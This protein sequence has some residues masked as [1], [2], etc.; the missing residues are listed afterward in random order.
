MGCPDRV[1]QHE[2]S[3][4]EACLVEVGVC[5]LNAWVALAKEWGAGGRGGGG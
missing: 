1:E 3:F 5:S 4:M 2:S